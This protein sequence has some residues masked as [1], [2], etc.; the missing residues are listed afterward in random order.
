MDLTEL[1]SPPLGQIKNSA[2]RLSCLKKKGISRVLATFLL[3]YV[4]YIKTLLCQLPI[5]DEALLSASIHWVRINSDSALSTRFSLAVAISKQKSLPS[6]G[7][8]DFTLQPA[9]NELFLKKCHANRW[10]HIQM[11]TYT[12]TH[13]REWKVGLDN[14]VSVVF[15]YGIICT[16]CVRQKEG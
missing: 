1:Q 6:C 7:V 3:S 13:K 9:K 12:Q 11:H 15:V 10:T 5:L 2:E 16:E 14:L 8:R 4:Y